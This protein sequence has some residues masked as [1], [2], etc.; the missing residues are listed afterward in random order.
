MGNTCSTVCSSTGREDHEEDLNYENMCSI[1]EAKLGLSKIQIKDLESVLEEVS[2]RKRAIDFQT[3][4]E[5]FLRFEVPKEE[6]LSDNSPFTVLYSGLIGTLEEDKGYILSTSLPFCK[7]ELFD[8]KSVLWRCLETVQ[9]NYISY[10]E[11]VDLIK[12][13]IIIP[14][15]VIPEMASRA[16][17]G[18]MDK[19]IQL[20]IGT[21]EEEINDYAKQYLPPIP[22]NVK[23]IHRHEFDAWLKR[24][25]I[26][27]L[28]V[29]SHHRRALLTYLNLKKGIECPG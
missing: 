27:K 6:F 3:L 20:L 12:M 17:V 28:F 2:Y 24:P 19:N 22:R 1:T 26:S 29:P 15:K 10:E 9:K 7:G 25:E 13:L 23:L 8:K 5:V 18:V 14:T 11:L 16:D 21:T 4:A